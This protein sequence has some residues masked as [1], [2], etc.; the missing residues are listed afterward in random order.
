MEPASNDGTDLTGTER[1]INPVKRRFLSKWVD[2]TFAVVV[3]GAVEFLLVWL[4]PAFYHIYDQYGALIPMQTRFVVWLHGVAGLVMVPA[5][6]VGLVLFQ[7]WR[8]RLLPTALPAD[9]RSSWD[10][11]VMLVV[12]L[13]GAV[14]FLFLAVAIL[15]PMRGLPGQPIRW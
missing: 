15:M 5:F 3:W 9:V 4:I 7:F 14:V 6:L 13:L 10:S 2:F 12:V 8:I 1:Q 11:K